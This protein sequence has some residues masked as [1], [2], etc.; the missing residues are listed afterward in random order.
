M[1]VAVAEAALEAR[2]VDDLSC[3]AVHCLAGHAGLGGRD[4]CQLRLENGMI[5]LIHLL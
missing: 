4:A 5:D 3:R 1:S 2:V